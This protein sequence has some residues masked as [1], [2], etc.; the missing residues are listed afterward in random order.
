MCASDGGLL[1]LQVDTADSHGDGDSSLQVADSGS[2]PEDSEDESQDLGGVLEVDPSL[3]RPSPGKLQLPKD[4]FLAGIQQQ[5]ERLVRYE[6]LESET[7]LDE[8]AGPQQSIYIEGCTDSDFTFAQKINHVTILNCT[9]I[10]V[11]TV[12]VISN[13]EIITSQN[14]EL[15]I[16]APGTVTF[17]RTPNS[18]LH[19]PEDLEEVMCFTT[20]S[21]GLKMLAHP[22]SGPQDDGQTQQQQHPAAEEEEATKPEPKKYELPQRIVDFSPEQMETQQFLIRYQNRNFRLT[23]LQRDAQG[24]IIN[25]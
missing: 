9:N 19:F 24:R 16:G 7:I 18:E 8:T 4:G 21:P 11:K 25:L 2:S 23:P 10:R 5:Q 6:N 22:S 20:G 14:C 3:Y 17:D 1:W 12:A 13:I 15:T